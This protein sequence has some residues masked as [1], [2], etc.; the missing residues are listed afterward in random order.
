[1]KNLIITTLIFFAHLIS[2]QNIYLTKVEKTNV[3]TDKFLYHLKESGND[4]QYLGEIE[5]QGFSKD[6]AAVFSQI[7]KKAKE[8]G[9]N[10]FSVKPFESIDENPQKFNASHYRLQLFYM[11][12]EKFSLEEGNLYLFAASQKDQK[13]SI[14][15]KDYIL[16]PRTYLKISM[17]SGEIYTIS[18]KKLLG[19]TIKIQKGA[20]NSDQYYQISSAR[21]GNSS[22]ND[23]TLHLKSGDIVGLEKSFAEF[24]S[25]IYQETK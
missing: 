24:L 13:I 2:A 20:K 11:P 5:V 1:M 9:A 25:V 10:S 17:I 19:S 16:Q 6:D 18:T 14:N 8:I 12:A 21:L 3:N 15:R 23:G 22:K 4:A 7:Y